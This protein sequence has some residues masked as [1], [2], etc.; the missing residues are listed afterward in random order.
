MS[1]GN[2]FEILRVGGTLSGQYEGLGEGALVGNFG[3]PG[4]VY[5]LRWHG[6][7]GWRGT[8]YQRGSR[9]DHGSDLVDAGRA[10]DDGQTTTL[11][12]VKGSTDEPRFT[13]VVFSCANRCS[14]WPGVATPRVLKSALLDAQ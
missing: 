9:T 12:I 13:A 5:H 6:R 8:V 2:V 10:G 7:R 4:P 3:G 11:V 14:E 1:R